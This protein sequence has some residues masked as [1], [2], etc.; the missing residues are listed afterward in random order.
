MRGIRGIIARRGHRL[1]VLLVRDDNNAMSL[2]L[3]LLLLLLVLY[4][5]RQRARAHERV[6]RVR[7]RV[8][9]AAIAIGRCAI[10]AVVAAVALDGASTI[11][12]IIVVVAAATTAVAVVALRRCRARTRGDRHA[13][14]RT[15]ALHTPELL[16]LFVLGVRSLTSSTSGRSQDLVGG[17]SREWRRLLGVSHRVSHRSSSSRRRVG[18]RA[19]IV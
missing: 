11:I 8:V 10:G 14:E 6:C 7:D 4:P 16:A 18:T 17:R 15:L 2:V 13:A 3:L 1:T 9:T 12:A 19:P 5:G